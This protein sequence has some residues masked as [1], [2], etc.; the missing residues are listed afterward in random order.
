MFVFA[1]IFSSTKEYV[2]F[3]KF[4]KHFHFYLENIKK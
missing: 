1:K 2:F 3:A 4:H